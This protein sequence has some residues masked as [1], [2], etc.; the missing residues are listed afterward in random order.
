MPTTAR[1]GE[2]PREAWLDILKGI[3]IV[4]VVA[5]HVTTHATLQQTIYLF[6]MPLFFALSGYLH[7]PRPMRGLAKQKLRQLAVP[8]LVLLLLFSILLARPASGRA[9]L[10]LDGP[11][12]VEALGTMGWRLYGGG[13]LQGDFA[14]FW[15][16]SCLFFTQ[17]IYNFLI[18]RL[19][20]PGKP[21]FLVAMAVAYGLAILAD[22]TRQSWQAPLALGVVPMALVYFW[23][24]H[25]A[26][27]QRIDDAATAIAAGAIVALAAGLYALGLVQWQINMKYQ[28]FGMPFAAPAT[29]L[30]LSALVAL[31]ARR[32]GALGLAALG[33]APARAVA[34]LAWL[35]RASMTVMFFHMAIVMH[36]PK[37]RTWTQELGVILLAIAVSCLIHVVVERS[38]L[39]RRVFLGQ[40]GAAAGTR[41][42]MGARP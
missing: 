34:G 22:A 6:H 2:R 36:L 3:G 31:L 27:R 17:L 42:A 25:L 21:R 8:Y 39:L 20:E 29:A 14:V 19:G 7:R 13:E 37:P 4:L 18:L 23:A 16:V 5:G 9:L 33:G 15:F 11:A 32:L 26:G 10:A 30:A 24:G 35:G 38:P 28:L 41:R 12:I 40:P 1:E